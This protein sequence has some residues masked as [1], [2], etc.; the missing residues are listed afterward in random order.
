MSSSPC[1]LNCW[2]VQVV[3]LSFW[4]METFEIEI[5]INNRL[6]LHARPAT[7]FAQLAS[8]FESAI[9]L[10]KGREMVDGKSILEVLTLACPKGSSLTVVAQGPDAREAVEALK[11]LVEKQFGEF[12]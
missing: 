5:V 10:K 6:G 7:K 3:L 9:W 2:R 8:T 4:I 1:V 11:E 12:D